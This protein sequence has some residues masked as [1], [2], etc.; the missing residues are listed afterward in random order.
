MPKDEWLQARRKLKTDRYEDRREK[1]LEARA[2]AFLDDDLSFLEPTAAPIVS[3]VGT[4]KGALAPSRVENVGKITEV[5]LIRQHTPEWHTARRGR[6][7]ASLAGACLGLS[8]FTSR[9]KAYRLIR[10]EEIEEENEHMR[11]GQ[12]LEPVAREMYER[13][14]GVKVEEAGLVIHPQLPWCAASPDGLIT[15]S[16]P[17][18]WTGILEIKAPANLPEEVPPW[19][20]IQ[21]MMQMACT[22][23]WFADYFAYAG[24]GK[25]FEKRI[26]RDLQREYTMLLALHTFYTNHVVAGVPPKKT[27]RIGKFLRD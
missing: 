23:R 21:M 27:F 2:D 9:A 10:G 4:E 11:R 20:E 13:R 1:K 5:T 6:I 24:L 25:I 3:S 22:G 17:M 26:F 12:L 7:T 19:H 14:H 8:P 18:P 16:C 15:A